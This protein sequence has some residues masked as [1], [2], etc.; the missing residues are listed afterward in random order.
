M[1]SEQ[2]KCFLSVA[3]HL[4]FTKAAKD[5]YVSQPAISH[6]ISEL[7]N[8]L[9]IKLFHRSTRSVAL[10]RAGELF[11]EDAKKFLDFEILAKNKLKTLETTQNLVLNIGY[12]SGPCKPFLPDLINEFHKSFPEV[13]INLIRHDAKEIKTSLEI[14]QYDVYFSMMEDLIR[15]KEYQCRKIFSELYCLVCRSDHPILKDSRLNF[16]KIAKEPFFMH[17]KEK[18]PYLAKQIIQVCKESYYNPH[19]SNYFN[20][21]EE[22]L[23]AVESGL[24][25][26]ILPYRFKYYLISSLTYTPLDVQTYSSIG[27][28]WTDNKENPAISWFM[29]ALNRY[30]IE[31]PD[32][33]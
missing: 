27:V 20:S 4:N 19:V 26:A 30:I 32:V 33:F 12:L 17:V 21:M 7:E 31:N 13:S 6:Q 14:K 22:L 16:D 23:F 9:G 5:F 3:N 25:I 29:D 8:E 24:G 10:T 18:A 2:L 15:Q 1:N 11:V 28:A